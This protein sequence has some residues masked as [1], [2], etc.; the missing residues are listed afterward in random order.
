VAYRAVLSLSL[1]VALLDAAKVAG[2]DVSA[3]SFLPFFDY[4]MGWLLPTC[5]A[6]IC[7]FF[8]PSASSPVLEEELA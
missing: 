3:F 6:M 7:M 8:I 4:G 1:L 2:F 5:A